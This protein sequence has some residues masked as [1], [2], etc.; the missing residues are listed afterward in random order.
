VPCRLCG[1][2]Q[3]YSRYNHCIEWGPNLISSVFLKKW[4]FVS[5]VC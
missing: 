4:N 2:R 3:Q 1:G 5:R